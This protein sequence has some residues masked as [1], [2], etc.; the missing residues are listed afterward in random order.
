MA[1]FKNK[2]DMFNHRADR[3]KREGKEAER[4]GN[5]TKSDWC[6]QQEKENREKAKKYKGQEGW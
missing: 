6:S 1:F 2:E 5:T 3:F 4:R